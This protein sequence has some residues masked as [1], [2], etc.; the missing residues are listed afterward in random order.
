MPAEIPGSILSLKKFVV[1]IRSVTSGNFI[2]HLCFKNDI[3]FIGTHQL[4]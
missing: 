2:F 1:I 3:V 4:K